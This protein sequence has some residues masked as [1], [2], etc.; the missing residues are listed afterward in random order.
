MKFRGKWLS[1]LRKRALRLS[2]LFI[3]IEDSDSYA[4]EREHLE[5]YTETHCPIADNSF[6]IRL[7]RKDIILLSDAAAI[8][9][10]E[11]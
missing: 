1:Y 2:R 3:K 11:G 6:Q 10:K 7:V 5:L 9:Y 8:L 4:S